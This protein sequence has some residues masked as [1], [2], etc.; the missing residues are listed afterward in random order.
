MLRVLAA[1]ALTATLFL[2][3]IASPAIAGRTHHSKLDDGQAIDRAWS[4][5]DKFDGVTLAGSDEVHVTKGDRWQIRASGD[6]KVLAELRFMVEKDT[7]TI[8]RR[9]SKKPV[10]GKAVIEITAPSIDSATLAGSGRLSLD[11]MSSSKVA[12]TIAGSGTIDVRQVE[13]RELS[14]TIAG[15]GTLVLAGR[16][17]KADISIAG[18]GD[19]DGRT[20]T[21][22]RANVSVAGSGDAQFRADDSVSASILGSG[23][24]T[25]T[26]TTECTQ[27]RM[28]SGRLRCST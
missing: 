26:G 27:S 10:P 9:W 25:V 17:E 18:S 6:P 11:S 14:A 20:L 4:A 2:S 8:G 21:L 16:A 7:L 24:V 5:T 1:F 12:A 19:L 22:Q 13:S 23:D 28:G 3:F 15:S